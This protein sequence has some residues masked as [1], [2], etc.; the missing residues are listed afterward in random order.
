MTT[1]VGSFPPNAFG[2]YDM[3]GNVW[4]WCQDA[5][6]DSYNNAPT[7]GSAWESAESR[8]SR[9]L[10]GGS[11]LHLPQYARAADRYSHAPD[12]RYASI[13]FRVCGVVPIE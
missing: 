10:R 1:P 12:Y 4:E 9:V 8:V 3:H 7:D 5:W 2:L 11:W 13:G 6:Y